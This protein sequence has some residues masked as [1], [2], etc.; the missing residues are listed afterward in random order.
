M[1]HAALP[2]AIVVNWDE[3]ELKSKNKNPDNYKFVKVG[4][5]CAICARKAF[6]SVRS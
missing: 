4:L 2:F 6:R 3:I 5:F 1:L